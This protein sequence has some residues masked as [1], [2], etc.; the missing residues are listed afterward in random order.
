MDR[1]E[2]KERLNQC[3][4]EEQLLSFP[5][6]TNSIALEIGMLLIKNTQIRNAAVAIDITVNSTE[7]FHYCFP[8]ITDYNN[9]WIERKKMMVHTKHISSLHAGYL[10]EYNNLDLEKDWFLD[11][12]EFAVKG[13]GFPIYI[14]GTACIGSISCSGLPHEQ[15]H[16]LIVDTL[17]QY[18]GTSIN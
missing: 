16:Q 17:N 10:L 9:L 15:D 14:N 12:K 7:V 8:G 6:F 13:G 1:S 4:K 3:E 18:L 5:T 2:L 11:P